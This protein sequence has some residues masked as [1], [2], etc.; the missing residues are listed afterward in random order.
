M[1][2][3]LIIDDDPDIVEAMRLILEAS[4]YAVDWAPDGEAGIEKAKAI[5]PDVIILDVMMSTTDEGFHVAYRMKQ[6]ASLSDIPIVMI[7]AVGRATGFEFDKGKDQEFLP[8][9]EFIEKPIQPQQLRNVIKR[10]L[11]E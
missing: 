8:V 10:V 7:T 5:H 3:V 6:D 9:D 4:G 2:R 11:G 1:H